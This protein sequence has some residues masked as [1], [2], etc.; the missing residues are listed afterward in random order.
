MTP[1]QMVWLMRLA[2]AGRERVTARR[3]VLR[4]E[5]C[6]AAPPSQRAMLRFGRVTDSPGHDAGR[7]GLP[8]APFNTA[9]VPGIAAAKSLAALIAAIGVTVVSPRRAFERASAAGH[10]QQCDC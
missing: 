4:L 7:V 3:V 8:G 5:C 9:A 2:S 1:K 6:G 10:E